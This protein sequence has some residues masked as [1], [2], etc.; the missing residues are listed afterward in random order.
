ME[1]RFRPYPFALPVDGPLAR[2]VESATRLL[3][4]TEGRFDG[5]IA[6]AHGVNADGSILSRAGRYSEA[7]VVFEEPS[8]AYRLGFA[9][10]VQ[11]FVE[12][13]DG[14]VLFQ[15]RARSIG[16]DPLRWTASASGGLAPGE[17]PRFAV[18]R[19]AAAEVGLSEEG[20][21]GLAPVAV[22]L[23]DDTGTALIVYRAALAEGA[24]PWPD[25]S[26][27]AE[28][29]WA[30]RPAELGGQVSA[31]TIGC[32]EALERWRAEEPQRA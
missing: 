12:R 19:D 6:F 20:L 11:L 4:R 8:L 1:P 29:R 14:S 5:P 7:T 21:A 3:A 26:K 2:S 30:A 28:V 10:G 23:N 32:F 15:L 18:M 25:A 22:C 27:V 31:D 13:A 16:R 9:L 24:E 17:E